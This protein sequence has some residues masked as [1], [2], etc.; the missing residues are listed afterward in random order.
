MQY[1][2]TTIVRL[3]SAIATQ[4][5]NLVGRVAGMSPS[6]KGEHDGG[7]EPR[8]DDSPALSSYPWLSTPHAK[9]A[10]VPALCLASASTPAASPGFCE[11]PER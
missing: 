2:I 10:G 8:R 11:T 9:P 3:T 5:V 4:T 6:A 1:S 7:L